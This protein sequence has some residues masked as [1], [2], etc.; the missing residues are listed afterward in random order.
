MYNS[1]STR[2]SNELG[3]GNPDRAR[4]AMNVTLKLT[5]ALALC[6]VVALS[7]GHNLWANIGTCFFKAANFLFPIAHSQILVFVF[8]VRVFL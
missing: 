6:V 4:S 3:A 5:V 2:V 7:F 8:Y 1:C